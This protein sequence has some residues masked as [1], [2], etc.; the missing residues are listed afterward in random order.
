MTKGKRRKGLHGDSPSPSPDREWVDGRVV[1]G[2]NSISQIVILS[3]IHSL[4]AAFLYCK[5][6][7]SENRRFPWSVPSPPPPH[8]LPFPVSNQE[9]RPTDCLPPPKA[10]RE[11]TKHCGSNRIE[12][13]SKCESINSCTSR[14]FS[15]GV[16]VSQDLGAV[17]ATDWFH[18]R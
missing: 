9:D 4:V 7:P 2:L 3:T 14:E 1:R 8:I 13:S 18:V 11:E 16:V 5:H 6:M 10:Q 17:C 15:C 12:R